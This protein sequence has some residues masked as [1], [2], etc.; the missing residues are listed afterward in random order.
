M[1]YHR[2]CSQASRVPALGILF[3]ARAQ[4]KMRAR[5]M[6]ISD[7]ALAPGRYLNI[8]PVLPNLLKTRFY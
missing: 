6:A 8:V 4:F 2:T 3:G 1:S 5:A 7:V